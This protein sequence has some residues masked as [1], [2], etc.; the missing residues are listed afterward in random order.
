MNV[1]III[2]PL[3]IG[4]A[5]LIAVGFIIATLRGQWDDLETPAVRIL[6]D[7]DLEKG[8]PE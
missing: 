8:D 6:F 5:V 3:S 7:D 2:L 4:L 1:L